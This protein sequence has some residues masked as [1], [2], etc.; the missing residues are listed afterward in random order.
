MRGWLKVAE[1]VES[2]SLSLRG[3]FEARILVGRLLASSGGPLEHFLFGENLKL[4]LD[5]ALNKDSARQ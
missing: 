3:H 2:W 4:E 1:M 5:L